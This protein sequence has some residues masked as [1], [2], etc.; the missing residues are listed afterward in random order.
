MKKII[1]IVVFIALIVSCGD[2]N[3]TAPTE[4]S[5]YYGMIV[6]ENNNPIADAE[7]C[8][9]PDVDNLINKIDRE[10]NITVVELTS[11]SLKKVNYFVEVNWTTASEMN[12][13]HFIIERANVINNEPESYQK[14]D[15]IKAKGN[16]IVST[17]YTYIDSNVALDN[18]YSYRLLIQD[19]DGSAD[20]SNPS[21]ISF[22]ENKNSIGNCY[23]NPFYTMTSIPISLK[24]AGI[25]KVYF[26]EKS[27]GESE[28][29]ELEFNAGIN[30]LNLSNTNNQ[31]LPK[32]P[33]VY[34]IK[35]VLNDTTLYS[36]YMILD[37]KF[38]TTDCKIP[39]SITKSDINGKFSL[40]N[41]W[42]G[43][44][45]KFKRTQYNG[46][47]LGEFILTTKRK[48][49]AR[50]LISEV[51]GT[52]EYLI[53]IDSI[54]PIPNQKIEGKIIMKKYKVNG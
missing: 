7:I 33:G 16:S 3:S 9:I 51:G 11:F 38:T 36:P 37:F 39:Q 46:I 21:E 48:I 5:A 20:Y 42:F 24:K 47:D 41:K 31:G 54:T 50:K 13:R 15:T 44:T 27:T 34:Q 53:G 43:E 19:N 35:M 45:T 30:T 18:I 22:R 12:S 25:A 52:K 49:V 32:R 2:N 29:F 4:E 1:F 8:L 26:I 17:N 10:E 23:P 14:I 28:L 6:D 40:D